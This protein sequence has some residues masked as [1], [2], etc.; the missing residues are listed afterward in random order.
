MKR[1][2]Y[3]GG[4]GE[5]FLTGDEPAK[6][7]DLEEVSLLLDY[8]LRPISSERDDFPITVIRGPGTGTV[9]CLVREF[10]EGNPLFG[11]GRARAFTRA[12]RL[13]VP[14]Q[15]PFK[16][17]LPDEAIGESLVIETPEGDVFG[18]ANGV[19]S[20]GRALY[21][22]DERAIYFAEEDA[23][24]EV[25]LS[26]AYGEEDSEPWCLREMGLIL[27]FPIL[28]RSPLSDPAFRIIEARRAVLSS[29]SEE[30]ISGRESLARASFI[31]LADEDGF[32]IRE[33]IVE[34]GS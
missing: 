5:L 18:R 25:I 31:L 29:F 16:I 21:K 7:A 32:L 14:T 33:R 22:P 24:R 15:K 20:P 30:F 3:T 17:N 27:L 23:G 1:A 19:P 26:Y 2:Y 13:V 34:A 9:S 4:V 28:G 10:L 6:L 8:S 12:L 11:V